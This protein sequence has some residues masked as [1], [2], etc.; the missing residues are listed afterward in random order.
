MTSAGIVGVVRDDSG[1]LERPKIATIAHVGDDIHVRPNVGALREMKTLGATW[2]RSLGVWKL[3]AV[4]MNLVWI[5]EIL[6]K[7]VDVDR[8]MDSVR[9]TPRWMVDHEELYKFQRL[10][11][12][13]LIGAERGQILVMSP[14]LGKTATSIVAAEVITVGDE[15][16]E[17][18]DEQV[19][20]VAPS[21]LLF[22]WEREIKRWAKGDASVAILHGDVDWD[23]ARQARWL[24]TSWETVALHQDWFTG[25]KWPLWILDESVK[26]K[27]RKST[28]AMA[29]GG[30]TRRK[31]KVAEDGTETIVTT[32]WANIRKHVDRVWLLSGSPTTKYYDDLWAQLHLIWP[33]AF[34]GYWRFA[35]RYCVVEESVWARK[36]VED[37]RD[38]DPIKDNSDLIYV[39]NQEDVH[40]LPSYIPV[41]VDLTLGPK[42]RQA[43]DEMLRGF[44]TTLDSGRQLVAD[45]RMDQLMKLQ[46]ITSYFEGESSKHDAL[47]ANL[48]AVEGPH[49][50][51]AHWIKGADALLERLVAEGFN[52]VHVKGGMNV[53]VSDR[54]VED[55]KAGRVDVLVLSPG[56]GKFGHTLINTKAVHWVDKTYNADDYFQ[57]LYRVRR[58][59]LLHRPYLFS[60]RVPGTTD[61]LVEMNLGGKIEGISR[62]TNA[63][64]KELLLGLGR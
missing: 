31:K 7:N 21:K 20:I 11:A 4:R 60:Y 42:Q 44:V 58:I 37:R 56:T 49:L 29:V 40:E 3:P 19:V 48:K 33:R 53:K 17:I 55:Y 26:A 51:W 9:K 6:G 62:V 12:G 30:G 13:R 10:A 25:A 14:G 22:M 27:S 61:D 39:V 63:R 16:A 41:T 54:L 35:E 23:V 52:A 2:D 43:Y 64:L 5:E 34:K 46:G 24:V 1:L 28:L 8:S 18:P 50:V 38:V 59:G 32:S 57:G 15:V 36:V 45:N 47:I